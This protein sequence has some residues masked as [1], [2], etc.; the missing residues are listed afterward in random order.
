MAG[1]IKISRKTVR[2]IMFILM[3]WRCLLPSIV[4]CRSMQKRLFISMLPVIF[5]QLL[6]RKISLSQVLLIQISWLL[7][8]F[9]IFW[10][11]LLPR[12]SAGVRWRPRD[13]HQRKSKRLSARKLKW[14][15]SLI[16]E[17]LIP[18]WVRS[19][20]SDITKASCVVVSWVWIRRLELSRLMWAVWIILTSCMIW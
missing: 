9:V 16:M 7:S 3:D 13:A 6:I 1:A 20:P 2:H 18:W 17:I 12:V 14:R 19:I 4:V 15:C 10:T 8:R 11:V 5:S